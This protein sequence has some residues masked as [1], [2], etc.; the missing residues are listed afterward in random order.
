MRITPPI[1]L[2]ANHCYSST[3]DT[4]NWIFMFNYESPDCSN[5]DGPI[6]QTISGCTVRSRNADSDFLLVELSSSPPGSY[7]AYFAG[8]SR[9]NVASL[10]S[11]GIHHPSGDI[12]KISF[13]NNAPVSS[14]YD[15]L[16]YLANSHWEVVAWDD[17]TTEG[18]SSGSPL[19]DQNSRII[20][21]LHGGWA[22]CN[23]NTADFY[24]KFSMSWDGGTSSGTRLRDWLDPGNTGIVTLNGTYGCIEN[25]IIDSPI[26][27][28]SNFQANNISALSVIANNLNVEFNGGKVIRMLPG[29]SVKSSSR[30]VFSATIEECGTNSISSSARSM[31]NNLQMEIE[32]AAIVVGK[33]EIYPNPAKSSVNIQFPNNDS[34]NRNAN[35]SIYNST[36]IKIMSSG[37]FNKGIETIDVSGF[38]RGLYIIQIRHSGRF[39]SKRIL[40]E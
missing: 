28:N 21:Q 39:T 40:L 5:T 23:S 15:P 9:A 6:D 24:G 29:F 12:K 11:T 35:I 38:T 22:S 4:E 27:S 25:L 34:A 18:G 2:T 36:G 30:S 26:T 37:V 8:W 7:N 32:S 17:G 19:F 20:G 13:D 3:A 31:S 10:S 33:V 16:P 14:D 1:F